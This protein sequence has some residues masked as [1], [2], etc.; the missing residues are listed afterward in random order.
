MEAKVDYRKYQ[1]EI[2]EIT[3]S[4]IA[5]FEPEEVDLVSPLVEKYLTLIEFGETPGASNTTPDFPLGFAGNIDLLTAVVIPVVVS[6]LGKL[7]EFLTVE[8]FRQTRTGNSDRAK[9]QKSTLNFSFDS[10]VDKL[11]DEIEIKIRFP[12]MSKKKAKELSAKILK[13]TLREIKKR[14]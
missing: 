11:K 10:K 3:T 2:Q 12:G 9:E 6:T 8:K 7:M 5:E 13:L 4:L 1:D 14:A